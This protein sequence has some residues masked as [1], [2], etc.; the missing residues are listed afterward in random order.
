MATNPG[1]SSLEAHTITGMSF[2]M[3]RG[4]SALNLLTRIPKT[5]E[6]HIRCSMTSL[7]S[8]GL[9]GTGTDRSLIRPGWDVCWKRMGYMSSLA[10]VRLEWP[11]LSNLWFNPGT[12][13]TVVHPGEWLS[14]GTLGIGVSISGT[15]WSTMLPPLWNRSNMSSISLFIS[16]IIMHG[17]RWWTPPISSQYF[18]FQFWQ[19]RRLFRQS[20]SPRGWW[21]FA[22]RVLGTSSS[23]SIEKR[24]LI[25]ALN[26]QTNQ[27]YLSRSRN[28][29]LRQRL[30]IPQHVLK[31]PYI[32]QIPAKIFALSTWHSLENRVHIMKPC[33][34]DSLSNRR[35]A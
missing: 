5:T 15:K 24:G 27:T 7:S 34:R 17:C 12:F 9:H 29:P 23:S 10:Q 16:Y 20:P 28:L 18:A 22:T 6:E 2:R 19:L 21:I 33:F 26:T 3:T 30:F 31:L 35:S 8:P 14:Q 32:I 1:G 13:F 4:V 25:A 11:F